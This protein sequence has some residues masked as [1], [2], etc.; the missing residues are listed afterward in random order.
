MKAFLPPG[1]FDLGDLFVEQL[2]GRVEV[3]GQRHGF[4]QERFPGRAATFAAARFMKRDA[5]LE[6]GN[7]F[8]RFAS[9]DK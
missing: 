1:E 5:G 2:Q 3:A 7:C 6:R 9:P 8:G 4:G